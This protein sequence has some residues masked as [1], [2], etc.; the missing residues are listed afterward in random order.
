MKDLRAEFA[1]TTPL[2]SEDAHMDLAQIG[3]LADW[4]A[5]KGIIER[6]PPV[7]EFFTNDF[8]ANP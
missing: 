6:R 7:R 2:L 1:A 4:M 5:A 3:R 8:L